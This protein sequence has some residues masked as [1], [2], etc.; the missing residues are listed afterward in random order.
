[1]SQVW[2]FCAPPCT[3]TS[4]G[5]PLPQTRL[6]T[7]AAGLD[8]HV[9]PAH[10][11]RAVVGQAVLGGVLVEEPELVV[12][13]QFRHAHECPI[14]TPAARRAKNAAMPERRLSAVVLAA[15]EG[16]RMR[17]ER[18]K[19]LHLLCG[20]PM[21]LHVLDAMAEIDVRRVV[22]VV[23]HR[24]EWVTKTLVQHAPPTMEIEFVE[25]L[26][27]HR[28]RRRAGRR[29]DRA[30]RR[31]RRGGGRGGPAGRHAAAAPA[32]P[33]RPGAGPPR[34]R[35]PGRPC[36]PPWSRTRSGYG[37]VVH[38]KDG[39]VARVVEEADATDEE[40]A[41]DEVNTSI[42]CFRRSILAP[43][44]RRLSPANAQ[45]EYYL[46]D[47]VGGPE[48][49]RLP[50]R[51]L[52]LPD[53]MEAAG[54]NDRAQLA[55]AEAELRDRINERWMRRGVTMWDP[56][57]TYVD[58]EV[59]ARGRRL[60]AA[61]RDPARRLRGRGRRRDR[62]QQRAD[63]HRGRRGRGRRARAS[64]PGPPSATGPGSGPT[65]CS[66][67]GPRWPGRAGAALGRGRATTAE[68]PSAPSRRRAER[69]RRQ[70]S[71][72]D[73]AQR[74]S[75]VAGVE[76]IPR[77]RL[78]LVSGRAH[79]TLA[80]DIAAHL[81]VE[82]GEANLREFANGEIYCK[83]DISIRGCD[84]FIIQTHARP[85]NDSLMEQLIMIDAAKRASAKRITAVCPYYGYSRQDRKST[86]TRAH[87]GQAG[88][89]HALGRRRRPGGQRRPALRADP[90]LLRHALR[91]P[92][93]GAG[94]RGYMREHFGGDVVVV[95]PDAGRVKVAERYSQHLGCDLALI[96]KTRPRG[97]LQRGQGPPRGR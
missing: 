1:M 56:E 84:V 83:Y 30:A 10:V 63:R 15:G 68:R 11:G 3:R 9:D 47:A 72:C 45:G 17:S 61:R 44:L 92:G 23:G 12:G 67:P 94:A 69:R 46:T 75:S 49:R 24:A 82:L 20:R 58:A 74:R 55:V 13:H 93:G 18:P 43:T 33:G 90:G 26:T 79:P 29:A 59:A 78:E 81:G 40:R 48:Q 14:R 42:Y 57:R 39:D 35:T 65:A 54:V 37:R 91:P 16:T 7:A 28:D 31:R 97:H 6:E 71:R 70:A 80:Q 50:V 4:S 25:Q 96:H 27:Q 5:G 34:S 73:A 87:H 53:S 85:V 89:R 38:G 88:G 36:S 21:I 76:L 22:V 60:A 77:R 86:G 95:A 51:S 19:P 2:A 32:D 8:L 66:S 52:V 41:I 64:A 62:A